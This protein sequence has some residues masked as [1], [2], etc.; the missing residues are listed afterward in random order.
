MTIE[1]GT[2][3]TGA[4]H[5]SHQRRPTSVLAVFAHPDDETIGAGALI[6]LLARAGAEISVLTATRG[7]RG[8][9]IPA[10]LRRAE[11]DPEAMAEL[12]DGELGEALRQLGVRRRIFLDQVAGSRPDGSASGDAARRL[13]DSG[14]RWLSPGLAG[15]DPDAGPD[16]LTAVP[17][18]ELVERVAV[19]IRHVRPEVILTEDPGGSYGHPDHLHVH[20]VVMAA[21]ELA[22]DDQ[23]A[24]PVLDGLDA[25]RT[26][27]VLWS[28]QSAADRDVAIAELRDLHASGRVGIGEAGRS[29]TPPSPEA[30][31]PSSAVPGTELAAT[32]DARPV[33]TAVLRALAAHRSQTQAVTPADGVR[34]A[35]TFALSNDVLAPVL[36]RAYLRAAPGY[37]VSP[38][39]ALLTGAETR[40]DGGPGHDGGSR[41]GVAAG[42]A[43]GAVTSG[44]SATSSGAATPDGIESVPGTRRRG[45]GPRRR[46][47]HDD[48]DL[49]A[50][51]GALVA[52][53]G[54]MMGLLTGAIGTVVHREVP[55][56][57]ALALAAV[58]AVV[59]FAR[60]LG[61]MTAAIVTG[62][63]VAI[64][65]QAMTFIG[66]DGSVLV[67]DS[68]VGYLWLFGAPVM[69]LLALLLPRRWFTD[70][71]GQA[72]TD[73]GVATETETD[74]GAATQ[75]SAP[76]PQPESVGPQPASPERS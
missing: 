35:G 14:M 12:R 46:R 52:V 39:R 21:V 60:A 13:C 69:A 38:V 32:L 6:A 19:V 68:A 36:D 76:S 47:P 62:L 50:I 61:G 18:D 44:G 33:I 72:E 75:T 26:P 73:A 74:A 57:M 17:V 53:L 67:T 63:T 40:H 4:H 34:L 9:I 43:G 56:G 45:G 66:S 31:P 27:T 23:A 5:P 71:R 3:D 20:R 25:W 37:D 30:T 64:V 10:E 2:A 54:L 11:G 28:A 55:V 65:V 15:P 70:R 59:T 42:P 24:S 51:A 58:L 29:L 22:A 1:T 49:S 7:E 48:D 16:A 41:H 8:E